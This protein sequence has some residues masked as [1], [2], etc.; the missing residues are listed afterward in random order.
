MDLRWQTAWPDLVSGW[1]FWASFV[2]FVGV[3]G[4]SLAAPLVLAAGAEG[5]VDVLWEVV[6][7][8][9][10]ALVS[11]FLLGI[12]CILIGNIRGERSGR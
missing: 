2:A 1:C 12:V 8:G 3:I 10:A 5:T 6:Q 11:T 9:F 7:F 4:V